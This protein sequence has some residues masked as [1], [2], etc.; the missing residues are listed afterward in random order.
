MNLETVTYEI[1]ALR[2]RVNSSEQA[3]FIDGC[4]SLCE[5]TR[6]VVL[7][8]AAGY[9][10]PDDLD[11]IQSRISELSICARERIDALNLEPE[12]KDDVT[13]CLDR[14]D[15]RVSEMSVMWDNVNHHVPVDSSPS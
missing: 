6:S 12:D 11:E 3:A 8:M 7:S 13:G 9:R 15:R 14:V 5:F 2:N 1:N 10:S 4:D